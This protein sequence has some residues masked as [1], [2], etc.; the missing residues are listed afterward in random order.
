MTAHK[1][2]TPTVSVSEAYSSVK[3]LAERIR[4]EFEDPYDVHGWQ[5]QTLG[6]ALH[7]ELKNI[8]MAGGRNIDLRPYVRLLLQTFTSFKWRVHVR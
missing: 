7:Y 4:Q 3:D 6:Y 5:L 1:A 8:R 2:F